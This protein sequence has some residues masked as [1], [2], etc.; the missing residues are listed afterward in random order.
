MV[1]VI[2]T[3]ILLLGFLAGPTLAQEKG[4]QKEWNAILKAARSEGK[5]VV[6]GPPDAIVR[7]E[8]PSKFTA[9]FGIPV[10]YI[11]G[12]TSDMAAKLR[13]ERRANHHTIDVAL[14]GIDTT[15]NVL[16][17]EKIIDPVK[18]LLILPDVLD[19]SKWKKGKPW[20]MDPEE[21]YV[22]RMLYYVSSLLQIN[23][24]YVK[25]DEIK[26]M[27]DLLDPKWKGKICIF[28]P[29]AGG[30][31]MG[32]AAYLYTLFG[33]EYVKRLYV[34]QKPIISRRRRQITDWFARG[35]CPISPDVGDNRAER[36]RSE[37]FSVLDIFELGDA[38]G[39]LSMA[40]G[41]LL[42]INRAPHP[43]AARV[44]VNWMASKEGLGV[45]SRAQAIPT[46][47]TDIDESFLRPQSIPRPD[48]KYFD[49][50]NW[51]YVTTTKWKLRER[52]KKLL[53][54]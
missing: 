13:V 5:V 31:G 43:N 40:T 36:L 10:E 32:T 30:T 25:P 12:R 2:V 20:F 14:A 11:A 8:L 18:P 3:T 35:R 4:W 38:S 44:F 41:S 50:S 49:S 51:D 7:R 6:K 46:T 29:T 1:S 45:Y 19:P 34:D 23:T 37:G 52:L 24:Q 17:K 42:L 39:R 9:R 54:R 21:K 48:V 27:K 53:R 16:Y 26:S 33:E 15:A 22:L 47:R 28:D